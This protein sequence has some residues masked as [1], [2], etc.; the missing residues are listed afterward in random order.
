MNKNQN[1]VP[2]SQSQLG[3]YAECAGHEGEVYY[4]LPYLYTFSAE[5]D[6]Q[7]L[8]DAVQSAFNA[9]PVFFSRITTD[10]NGEPVMVLRE[11]EPID[12]K[13]REID[14]IEKEKNSLLEPMQLDGGTLYHLQILHAPGHVY[15]FADVHHIIADGT[16]MKIFIKAVKNAYE[17]NAVEPE[18]ISMV[19]LNLQEVSRRQGEAFQQNR[20]WYLKTFDCSDV[21]T[22]L[23]PD[24][25]V[26]EKG[27][28]VMW[29]TLRIGVAE[30]EAFGKANGVF[31]S[32]YFTAAYAPLLAKTAGEE[33]SPSITAAKIKI[34]RKLLACS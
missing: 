19:E 15:L 11:P 21:N 22:T 33:E 5:M 12:I 6:T 10:E 13:I 3:I 7:R 34:C 8:R 14:D 16:T 20:E 28:R 9:H 2:L 25:N 26:Q 1:V 4:Q 30:V 17:G 18:L 29:R 24:S 32:N 27:E 23:L 31:N